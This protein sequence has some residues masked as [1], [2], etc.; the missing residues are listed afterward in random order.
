MKTG[1]EHLKLLL[2]SI[3][4]FS[5]TELAKI[6]DKFFEVNAPKN[7]I[8]LN[9][10]EVC[11]AFYFVNE[12]CI[13]TY[14]LREDG[15]EKTRLILPSFSIGTA[16]SS[17]IAKKPSFEFVDA[18]ENSN[19]FAISRSDFY[20]LVSESQQ[21]SVFYQK[22]LEMAY[23]FQNTKIEHLITLSASE[24]YEMLQ[25]ENPKL[26]QVVSNKI[27]ASYLDIAPETLS[28][29]RAARS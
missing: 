28:R 22:I 23:T 20:E 16:L 18:L 9:N 8:L 26:L 12:G 27:I 15:S 14:F 24:R 1:K 10:G 4:G 13:R 21:W 17:F 7:R 2:K 6:A 5:D 25:K 29:I 19:L 3:S 11:D